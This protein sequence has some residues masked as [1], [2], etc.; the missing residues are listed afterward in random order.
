MPKESNY[1]NDYLDDNMY[2]KPNLKQKAL[3]FINDKGIY[4]NKLDIYN[5]NQVDY[6][7]IYSDSYQEQ[8]LLGRRSR[9]RE[10][11]NAT[12]RGSFINKTYS[13]S[14]WKHLP[15]YCY[16]NIGTFEE[17]IKGKLKE[18]VYYKKK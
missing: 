16:E 6:D 7:N 3:F 1:S 12:I 2:Y 10:F 17:P 11:Y 5:N 14:C 15:C 13:S 4:V 9:N 18:V 8:S